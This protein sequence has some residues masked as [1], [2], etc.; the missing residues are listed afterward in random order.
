MKHA[1]LPCIECR[2]GQ[3]VLKYCFR[4]SNRKRSTPCGLACFCL[5]VTYGGEVLGWY[6]LFPT[7]KYHWTWFKPGWTCWGF[8]VGTW[9]DSN[10]LFPIWCEQLSALHAI[11]SVQSLGPPSSWV[12][13]NSQMDRLIALFWDRLEWCKPQSSL[14]HTISSLCLGVFSRGADWLN[15][16]SVLCMSQHRSPY[17]YHCLLLIWP[18]KVSNIQICATLKAQLQ[19]R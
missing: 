14:G 9:W 18:K 19:R 4:C 7:W 12:M 11:R 5:C 8:W 2:H 3:A 13:E 1:L 17:K 16:Y 6:Q 10:T 15:C